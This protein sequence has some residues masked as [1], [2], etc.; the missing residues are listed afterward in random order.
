MQIQEWLQEWG[1]VSR[2]IVQ[3]HKPKTVR[4]AVE[5]L[6][7]VSLEFLMTFMLMNGVNAFPTGINH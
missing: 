2:S 7:Q 3:R 4:I 6:L 5:Q 1:G